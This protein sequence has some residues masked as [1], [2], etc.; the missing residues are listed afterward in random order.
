[1]ADSNR[2]NLEEC[3]KLTNNTYANSKNAVKCQRKIKCQRRLL[4]S[5]L[6]YFL[7]RELRSVHRRRN[8]N[9]MRGANVKVAHP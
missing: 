5:V 1:M 3:S 6:C 7:K 8:K 9:F 4:P 2:A